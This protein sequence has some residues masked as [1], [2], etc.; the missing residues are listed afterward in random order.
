MPSA[1]KKKKKAPANPARGFATQS[2]ASKPKVQTDSVSTSANETGKPSATSTPLE[3]EAD[4][5]DS[6]TKHAPTNGQR[7]LHELSPEELEQRLEEAEL[8][9]IAEKLS[10]KSQK[11]AARY[12]SKLQTDCR[13]LRAQAQS[14]STNLIPTEQIVQILDLAQ[15]E[16]NLGRGNA[17]ESSLRSN[18]KI[19]T[20]EDL[21]GRLWTLQRS[22]IAL[23]FAN[24]R[25][26]DALRYI[27]QHQTLPDYSGQLWGLEECLDWL[28]LNC[29]VEELPV[30]DAYT[31]KPKERDN[32]Q[33]E[34]G[35]SL[36]LLLLHTVL[37]F[38]NSRETA[39]YNN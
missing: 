37:P 6:V 9:T 5:N 11:D 18:A 21:T 15:E 27:V 19:L 20:E 33:Q 3:V 4:T 26:D 39:S 12:V 23:G 25:V 32:L 36:I 24:E 35:E 7:E 8:Q 29:A 16:V 34:D 14:L 22:L 1:S 38:S 10:P 30:F 17:D 13:L 28:V 2:I 31:G